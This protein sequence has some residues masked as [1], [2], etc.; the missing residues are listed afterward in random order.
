MELKADNSPIKREK[1]KIIEIIKKALFSLIIAVL[2]ALYF[3]VRTIVA[4]KENGESQAIK[5]FFVVLVVSMS[6]L[7]LLQLIS[8]KFSKKLTSILL[9][10]FFLGYISFIAI[11]ERSHYICKQL[12]GDWI[13]TPSELLVF[14]YRVPDNAG[15]CYLS[16]TVYK[17]AS[18]EHRF[19]FS[20]Y[21]IFKTK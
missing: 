17:S 20:N 4:D 2:P 7:F 6:V 18:T 19:I 9:V 13:K 1:Y 5:S 21:S 15:N 10:M 16:D 14:K 12:G 3:M 8:S 11:F